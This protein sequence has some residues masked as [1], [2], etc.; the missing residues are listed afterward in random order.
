MAWI[1]VREQYGQKFEFSLQ[2][3]I[4]YFLFKNIYI[5]ILYLKISI[6]ISYIKY[7]QDTGCLNQQG[8]YISLQGVLVLEIALRWIDVIIKIKWI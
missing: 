3:F 2:T 1:A 8:V 5:T 6:F 4:I 7:P